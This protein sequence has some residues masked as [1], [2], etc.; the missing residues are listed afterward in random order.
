MSPDSAGSAIPIAFV[1]PLIHPAACRDWNDILVRLGE[2]LR[3][4]GECTRDGNAIGIV[5]AN[6][7]AEL[8]DMPR[9]VV[10]HRI[11]L[12]PPSTSVFVGEVPEGER[13]AV[14]Q[15]DKGTKVLSGSILARDR[16]ASYIMTVDA[17]DLISRRLPGFVTKNAGAAGWYVD[18]GWVL[19]VGKRWA[20]LRDNFV[21][22]CGTSLIIRSDLLQ[23]PGDVCELD[24]ARITRWFGS[25]KFLQ[26]DLAAEGNNLVPVPFPAS[27][28]RTGHSENNTGKGTIRDLYFSR[29][30]TITTP[31]KLFDRLS[32][33][34]YFGKKLRCEFN[35]CDRPG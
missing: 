13:R 28:Y 1:V 11:S 31:T 15:L 24:D 22:G 3:S 23:L 17:D 4:I 29:G 14:K 16:G 19:P 7:P 5:V 32:R 18:D 30:V 26:G 21:R 25:H 6:E 27:V 35:A 34:R 20:Y 10:V 12:P 9:G 8:P 33:L 2:T